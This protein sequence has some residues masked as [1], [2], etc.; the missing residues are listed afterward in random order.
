MVSP[1]LQNSWDAPGFPGDQGQHIE[2]AA[3]CQRLSG[4]STGW[5]YFP[6]KEGKICR[7]P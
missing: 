2:F 4:A 6:E 5:P 7:N 1:F 3:V